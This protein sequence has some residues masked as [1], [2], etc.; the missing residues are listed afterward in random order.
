LVGGVRFYARKEVKDVLS[1]LR[2][3]VNPEDTVVLARAEKLG[4][5][6]LQTYLGWIR[7][8]REKN[9]LPTQ[10]LA[11]LDDVLETT[12]Y[13]S[14]YDATLPEE[15]S[16]IE[17]IQELRSVAT[18]FST[19]EEFL[20]NVSLVQNDTL[21]DESSSKDAD[22]ASFHATLM[23]FHAAKGLE[24]DVVFMVGME[25]GLF[26]HSR[27][28]YDVDELEEERRLCY[29]GITRARE[30]LYMSFTRRRM[31]YGAWTGSIA[32]RFLSE[33]PTELLL[34]MTTQIHIGKDAE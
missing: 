19:M 27:V 18:D 25:E 1:Y 11:L 31:M 22:N 16:R 14:R 26:P 17:N 5:R 3:A 28:L 32:S 10:P 4:K 8:N 15:A 21:P 20:E 13:V 6:Q 2:L 34:N 23:S 30:Q 33:I 24:F 12:R 29:V 9:T 7:E